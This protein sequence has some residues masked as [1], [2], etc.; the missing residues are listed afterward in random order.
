MIH[1]FQAFA[2]ILSKDQQAI[3]K[4]RAFPKNTGS[5]Q[6][7]W[8]ADIISNNVKNKKYNGTGPF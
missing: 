6:L 5:Q 2:P 4:T 8:L 3:D 1:V 7:R